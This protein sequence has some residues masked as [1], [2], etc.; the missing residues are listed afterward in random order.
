MSCAGDVYS[1]HPTHPTIQ[2]LA[3]I[4]VLGFNLETL[5]ESESWRSLVQA[6]PCRL[7]SQEASQ[8]DLPAR[9]GGKVQRRRRRG[10]VGAQETRGEEATRPRILTTRGKR[11]RSTRVK[12]LVVTSVRCWS[13]WGITS[14]F[15]LLPPPPHLI[16]HLPLPHP[17]FN[18]SHLLLPLLP[19]LPLRCAWRRSWTCST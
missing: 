1:A 11:G 4:V 6:R 17:P 10:E 14:S 9:R 18:I 3:T 12:W 8:Q 15:N 19:P 2:T 16:P 7:S 13:I 5:V